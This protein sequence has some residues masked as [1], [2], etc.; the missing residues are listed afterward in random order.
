MNYFLFY[1]FYMNIIVGKL[2]LPEA[3]DNKY[4]QIG[5]AL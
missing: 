4:R 2:N 5:K 1:S 3:I